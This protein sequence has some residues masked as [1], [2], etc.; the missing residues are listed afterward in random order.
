MAKP[1]ILAI[2]DERAVLNAVAGDLRPHYGR[3]YRVETAASGAEALDLLQ[4]M[5]KRNRPVALL[6]ADQRMPEMDGVT[7]LQQAKDLYPDA[8]R[9]LLTAYADTEAAIRAINQVDLH[10]Y[11]QKPWDPPEERLYPV[12]DDLLETWRPPPPAA[13]LRIIGHRWSR[14]SHELREFL[15]R[16][17]VPY[18]WLDVEADQ[19]EAQTLLELVGSDG[20]ELPVAVFADGA[21]LIQPTA[22][23]LAGRIGLRVAAERPFYDLVVVGAGPA[24]LAAA[25]YGASEGLQTLLVE[26][27]APGGQAGMSSKIM[28]Y[29][30]FPLGL[31]GADLTNRARQQAVNFKAEIVTPQE[32]TSLRLQDGYHIVGLADGSEVSSRA[33]IIAT[34]VAYRTLD[35]PGAG[36]LQGT[37]VYYSAS[38]IEAEQVRG[39]DAYVVGGG[40][41]AG[42]AALFLAQYAATVTI[43][44]RGESL[45]ATMSRYLIDEIDAAPNVELR[46]KTQV[47]EAKGSGHLEALTL[48]RDDGASETVPAAGLFIFI[49]MAPRTDWVA[50]VVERDPKGF[51]Y[52]GSDLGV[53][54]RG[55]ALER[56]PFPLETSVP[57][58]FVAG[59]VRAGSGKRVAAAVGEGSMAVRFIHEHLASQ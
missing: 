25:V 42:Q 5:R 10:Y 52:S 38:R 35:V 56:P 58:V 32:A 46:P 22:T 31:S 28:N 53:S 41:S 6:L 3:D 18:Q 24:G 43:L 54:P 34:G 23:E 8:K 50:G 16:N 7:F 59:D 2:D 12:L 51:I 30:G 27:R 4:E 17:L 20:T 11:L 44:I 19:E 37:G 55:W 49:G 57:G 15:A 1:V 21:A 26:R 29:L 47:A 48:L 40:N 45:A 14:A 39:G 36:D 9:A 33:L 13:D